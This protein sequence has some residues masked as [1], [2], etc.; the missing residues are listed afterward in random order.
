[1]IEDTP[2]LEQNQA[3]LASYKVIPTATHNTATTAANTTT[4][5]AGQTSTMAEPSHTRQTHR[6]KRGRYDPPPPENTNT[7]RRRKQYVQPLQNN[8]HGNNNNNN[9]KHHG[10]LRECLVILDIYIYTHTLRIDVPYIHLSHLD[11]ATFAQQPPLPP[12]PSMPCKLEV[13]IFYF[14]T[15]FFFK[16]KDRCF[17]THIW[18]MLSLMTTKMAITLSAQATI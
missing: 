11:P 4:P 3:S 18:G 8:N 13:C 12:A 9:N 5:T 6:T 16:K 15:F 17:H 7:K 1:M 2:P 10:K 14:I